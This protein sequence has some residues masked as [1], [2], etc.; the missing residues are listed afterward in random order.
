MSKNKVSQPRDAEKALEKVT[1]KSPISTH[2]CPLGDPARAILA[3]KMVGRCDIRQNVRLT[4][5]S[6]N[7][8]EVECWDSHYV[9]P[10]LLPP[11]P[12]RQPSWLSRCDYSTIKRQWQ[13]SNVPLRKVSS[14]ECRDTAVSL[15]PPR[16]FIPYVRPVV[17]GNKLDSLGKSVSQHRG[18]SNILETT[19][20]HTST[21]TWDRT[22]VCSTIDGSC[23]IIIQTLR[24]WLNWQACWQVRRTLNA[25][26]R[27]AH[28][29][30]P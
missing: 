30:R 15:R 25:S 20:T 27:M 6:C 14:A 1:T 28:L 3:C 7:L 29:Q 11:T 22:H 9:S 17:H 23:N 10:P 21:H 5:C 24:L 12:T 16:G 18:E 2:P 8:G 13:S 26:V 4:R 19:I